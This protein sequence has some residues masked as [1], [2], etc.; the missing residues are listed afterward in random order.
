MAST[1]ITPPTEAE[2]RDLVS[3]LTTHHKGYYTEKWAAAQEDV[4]VFFSPAWATPLENAYLWLTGWKPST[5][6]GLVANLRKSGMALGSL[7]EEQVKRIEQ[8][9]MKIKYEEEKVDGEM[10]R[11]QVALADRRL[12][13]LARL[14]SRTT[15]INEHGGGVGGDGPTQ[16]SGMVD[17]AVRSMAVG[18]E[19]VMKAADCVRLKTLKGLLDLM[20]PSQCVEFLAAISMLQIRLR[21][22]GQIRRRMMAQNIEIQPK[23]GM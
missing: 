4:L 10:E 18:L 7:S 22:C 20:S 1:G 11:Q 2:L 21:Q 17:V 8:L 15:R 13:E 9:R 16:V 19:R 12:V 6:F 23:L 5:A 14:A 3:R